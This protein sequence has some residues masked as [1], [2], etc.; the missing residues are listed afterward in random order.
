[1]H[2][3]ND[4]L[5]LILTGTTLAA[6]MDT[7]NSVDNF[8][9]AAPAAAPSTTAYLEQVVAAPTEHLPQDSTG[10]FLSLRGIPR[11][12]TLLSLFEKVE[13]TAVR[14]FVYQ[15]TQNPLPN[16]GA[17]IALIRFGIVPRG[18]RTD[19]GKTNVVPTIPS[20][21]N[22]TRSFNST[23]TASVNWGTGGIPFPAGLE[24]DLR[25]AEVRNNY[26]EF[27]IANS[28]PT[29][30]AE[31]DQ[32]DKLFAAQLEVTLKCSGVNFGAAY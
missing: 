8:G 29:S 17:T 1:M 30:P 22:I 6:D 2:P 11:I 9:S 18:T 14:A 16:N 21:Y 10:I 28:H 15:C 24:L 26:P 31:G 25:S 4:N 20:L 27:L 12:R 3:A 19:V 32:P 5:P 23:A 13:V 7:S